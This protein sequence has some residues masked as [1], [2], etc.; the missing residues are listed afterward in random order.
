MARP[1]DEHGDRREAHP[2]ILEDELELGDDE[3]EDEAGNHL[4][5]DQDQE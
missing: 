2:E 1:D 4:H 3:V 5:H